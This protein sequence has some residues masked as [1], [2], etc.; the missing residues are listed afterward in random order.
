[1]S[2]QKCSR[3]RDE[4][5]IELFSLGFKSCDKCIAQAREYRKNNPEKIRE[6]NRKSREK[7]RDE[8]NKKRREK[9]ANNGYLYCHICERRVNPEIWDFHLVGAC[10]KENMMKQMMKDYRRLI[11]EAPPEFKEK[12]RE[13][14]Q[15]KINDIKKTLPICWLNTDLSVA[16]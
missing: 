8:I 16:K 11:E 5:E 3:C 9:N 1:M 12:Y 15:V 4:K 10:H 13:E 2:K 7:N 6:A 14:G